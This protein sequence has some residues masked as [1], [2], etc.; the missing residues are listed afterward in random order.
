MKRAT[1]SSLM[2]LEAGDSGKPQL[3]LCVLQVTIRGLKGMRIEERAGQILDYLSR[4]QGDEEQFRSDF[5]TLGRHTENARK[6][7]KEAERRLNQFEDKLLAPSESVELEG[8][9]PPGHDTGP[10]TSSYTV[11]GCGTS[12]RL[13]AGPSTL[14]SSRGERRE[15]VRHTGAGDL[16]AHSMGTRGWGPLTHARRWDMARPGITTL[17]GRTGNSAP[18]YQ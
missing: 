8:L 11:P 13:L 15:A 14:P 6:K 12:D 1:V 3:F 7:Y 9:P 5:D 18:T 17:Q 16:P 2:H 10:A 4:L